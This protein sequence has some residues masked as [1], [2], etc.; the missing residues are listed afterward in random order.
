VGQGDSRLSHPPRLELA[1][2]ACKAEVRTFS[3]RGL[4]PSRVGH[5]AS[6]LVGRAGV[7][8]CGT[9][10]LTTLLSAARSGMSGSIPVGSCSTRRSAG[11]SYAIVVNRRSQDGQNHNLWMNY[12]RVIVRQNFR[13]VNFKDSTNRPFGEWAMY[14]ILTG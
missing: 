1:L 8:R 5:L 14:W 3:A 12:S 11:Q 9:K 13:M 6:D 4:T 7:S 10:L 2:D